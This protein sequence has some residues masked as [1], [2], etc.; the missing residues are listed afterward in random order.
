MNLMQQ[1]IRRQEFTVQPLSDDQV[2]QYKALRLRAL[3]LHPEAFLENPKTFEMKSIETITSSMQA[4]REK[5][6]F[7]LVAMNADRELVGTASLAVGDS[8]KLAHRGLVWG[9][10]VAPEARGYGV[11]RQIMDAIIELATK[12]PQFKSLQL[13]VVCSNTRAFNLY[14][15]L[16]FTVYGTDKEA[17]NVNG[18]YL[19][20][21]LMVKQLR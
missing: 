11:A 17:L 14:E 18:T 19:D 3:Q 1:A 6:G 9:V 12:N 5:G 4:A 16:G 13:G 15:S 8:E 21:Y 10:Y 20:E 7:T 2:S